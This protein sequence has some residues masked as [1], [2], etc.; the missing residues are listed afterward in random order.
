MGEETISKIFNAGYTTLKS[1]LDITFDDLIQIDGFGES[2]S[3]I[4]LDNNKKIMSGLD[5]VTLMHAS[6]C[7]EGI[8][9]VKA[10]KIL[11]DMSD[12]DD[13]L[14]CSFY[15]GWFN[16]SVDEEAM[17][18][19]SKTMQSFYK[20]V[21]PFYEFL[22]ETKIPILQPSKQMVSDDGICKGMAVCFS[23]VRDENLEQQIIQEG[24]KIVSGVSKNTTL[25]VVKDKHAT[26]SKILK[27]RLLN[28]EVIDIEGFRYR[29]QK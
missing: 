7:F 15:Q 27:A 2:V 22:S 14:I 3:N 20:G 16:C 29:L 5:M 6:D 13:E 12:K 11:D 28:I 26:S 9:K 8:G 4:I 17:C 10:Q 1:I 25:L 24:G 23:G 21:G 19:E 18:R